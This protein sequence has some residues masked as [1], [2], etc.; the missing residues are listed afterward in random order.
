MSIAGNKLN[1]NERV[2][3]SMVLYFFGYIIFR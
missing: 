3:K 2:E 1:Q